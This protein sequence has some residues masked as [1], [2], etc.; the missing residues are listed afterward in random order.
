MKHGAMNVVT[1]AFTS[2]VYKGAS[3]PTVVGRVAYTEYMYSG[4]M[5][6]M[7]SGSNIGV[8]KGPRPLY[9]KTRQSFIY[10]E[11]VSKIEEKT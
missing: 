7:V 6:K 1:T 2:W 5:S 10:F 8:Y 4:Y 11:T 9:T 3:R